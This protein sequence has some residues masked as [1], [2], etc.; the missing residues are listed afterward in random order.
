MHISLRN[1]IEQSSTSCLVTGPPGSGKTDLLLDIYANQISKSQVSPEEVVFIS[2]K[3][4]QISW[5][6]K[7]SRNDD[8]LAAK[9]SRVQ[10]KTFW[11]VAREIIEKNAIS[12]QLQPSVLPSY[13]YR[14]TQVILMRNLLKDIDLPDRFAQWK[15]NRRFA[16]TVTDALAWFDN[17]CMSA[18]KLNFDEDLKWLDTVHERYLNLCREKGIYFRENMLTVASDL[19]E[20]IDPQK[21]VLPSV[22]LLLIDDGQNLNFAQYR[23]LVALYRALSTGQSSPKVVLSGNPL[24]ALNAF[25]GCSTFF[26]EK[27]RKDLH[28]PQTHCIS[29]TGSESIAPRILQAVA[30]LDASAYKSKSGTGA[31][32][33]MFDEDC[34]HVRCVHTNT[35][36]DEAYFIAHDIKQ[37]LLEGISPDDIGVVVSKSDDDG[38]FLASVFKSMDIPVSL[39][40]GVRCETTIAGNLMLTSLKLALDH[41]DDALMRRFIESPV[42]GLSAVEGNSIAEQSQ[43]DGLSLF[44]GA[45]RYADVIRDAGQR[46][47]LLET[48]F[49]IRST[50]PETTM[51]VDFFKAIAS[52]SQL[53]SFLTNKYDIEKQT[54]RKFFDAVQYVTQLYSVLKYAEQPVVSNIAKQVELLF[55]STIS[56]R[57]T[58][59][60]PSVKIVSL[61]NCD[62]SVFDV[63]FIPGIHAQQF[64]DSQEIPI[65]VMFRGYEKHFSKMKYICQYDRDILINAMTRARKELILSYPQEAGEPAVWFDQIKSVSGVEFIEAGRA[66]EMYNNPRRIYKSS[67]AAIWARL[68]VEKIPYTQR[69]TSLEQLE[70]LLP[71]VQLKSSLQKPMGALCVELPSDFSFSPTQLDAYLECPRKFFIENV[72]KIQSRENKEYM[73][74]GNVIHSILELFHS[75]YRDWTS[76]TGEQFRV[77]GET[78]KYIMDRQ[79]EMLKG[80]SE[81]MRRI[82]YFQAQTCI[83]NYINELRQE[84]TRIV[85]VEKKLRFY[86]ES[87][88][89]TIKIDRIDTGPIN[90][91][92]RIVDYKTTA[93]GRGA[94]SLRNDF[95]PDGRKSGPSSYQLPIYYFAVRNILGIEPSELSIFFLQAKDKKDATVSCQRVMLAV[96]DGKPSYSV[97]PEELESVKEGIVACVADIRR[98]WYPLD[99]KKCYDCQCKQL[100][101]ALRGGDDE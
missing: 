72:L 12:A 89:F 32:G 25:G 74:F 64:P 17:A 58:E 90:G 65:P 97:S 10:I 57:Q 6:K 33:D 82:L 43:D 99:T 59:R 35:A 61:Y 23:L 24:F 41:N 3:P 16:E 101:N 83:M 19:L 28:I 20:K 44:Y 54:V 52:K 84:R 55:P 70:K 78:L 86:F 27:A 46:T 49:A 67:D 48:I 88:P 40:R 56:D 68:A 75:V 30:A 50:N 47:I 9:S 71:D 87:I 15:D 14:K 80:V 96:E 37:K 22:S 5:V 36:L 77:A 60:C 81:S 100:C 18:V 91:G 73:M 31:L 38:R 85:H 63:L 13:R 94:R 95:L 26:L 7:F 21:L 92:Y 69:E 51:I 8:R 2:C 98:G 76:P 62:S 11:D 1:L 45:I 93:K 4:S 53:Y 79:L 34:G 29:L 39:D 42:F 66:F